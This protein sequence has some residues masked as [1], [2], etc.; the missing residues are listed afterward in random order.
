MT[1]SISRAPSE[2]RSRRARTAVVPIAV[3]AVLVVVKTAAGLTMGS[4]S[5]LGSA[6]DSLLDCGMSTVNL[7]SIRK[8][9]QPPDEEHSF[10]HGKAESLAVLLEGT[11][12]AA[13]GLYLVTQGMLHLVAPRALGGYG[14]GVFV[15]VASLL[16]SLW[17]SRYL[18]RRAQETDSMLLRADSLHYASDVWTSGGVLAAIGLQFAT[19]I[20]WIDPAVSLAIAAGIFWQVRPIL[21]RAVDDL[22]DREL[23]PEDRREIERILDAH[24]PD[25]VGYH[26]LRT[27]R[28]G[29][30]TTVDVHVVIC[31]ERPFEEAHALVTRVERAIR[32]RVPNADVLV[33][34]DPCSSAPVT[35]PG[36]HRP[37]R[38]GAARGETLTPVY[39]ESVEELPLDL[40]ATLPADAQELYLRAF[41]R[42]Y[43][44]SG[45]PQR[46]AAT[47]GRELLPPHVREGERWVKKD[48]L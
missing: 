5:V 35:C 25:I 32:E 22:M 37:R 23:D 43:A 8:A 11:L 10:G 44:R 28:S 31:K 20:A 34:A 27:R 40:R 29:P 17:L 33:H 24:G 12:I 13:S 26:R 36:P 42:E 38:A 6:I 41:N 30:R 2:S 4:L 9:A 14:L 7:F 3:S 1:S 48:V 45:S 19:G 46:A 39:Y 47:A 16:A 18:V 21:R 15:M